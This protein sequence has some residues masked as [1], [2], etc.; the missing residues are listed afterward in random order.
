MSLKSDIKRYKKKYLPELKRQ[1]ANYQGLQLEDAIKLAVRAVI[2]SHSI[3]WKTK[4]TE[5]LLHQEND[6]IKCRT[7]EDIY[8]IAENNIKRH[9]KKLVSVR[10]YDTALRIGFN[11]NIRPKQVYISEEGIK[12]FSRIYAQTHNHISIPIEYFSEEIQEL[13]PYEI[14]DFL[15]IWKEKFY[16]N[17]HNYLKKRKLFISYSIPKKI[18]IIKTTVAEIDNQESYFITGL[19]KLGFDSVVNDCLFFTQQDGNIDTQ[20]KFHI[21]K[22]K[23]FEASAVFLRKQLNG[24]YKPQ[25]YLYDYTGNEFNESA[26]TDIQ[27]K[28]WSN[29]EIPLACIFY[30]SEIKILDCTTRIKDDNTP[31]YLLE[32]LGLSANIHKLYNSQLAFKLKSGVFWEQEELKNK[33]KFQNSAYDI[34]ISHIKKT[35]DDFVEEYKNEQPAIISKLIIQSILIKYLEERVDSTGGKLFSGKYFKKFQKA[36]SFTDVLRKQGEC[37][38]LFEDLDKD[39]NGNIFSWSPEEKTVVQK[40]NLNTLANALDAN[41]TSTHGQMS[42]WRYYE[43]NYVPVELISRLYEE[44]LGEDKQE[45]GLFYTPSHLVK[46]LVDEAM[47]LNNYQNVDVE[48]YKI[49]DPA[50]GSGVFLVTAYKRLIQWWRL[51]NSFKKPDLPTLKNIL[52]NNIHGVDKEPQAVRL[53]AFSLCLAL[54]DELTPKQI[55]EDLE[56]EDLTCENILNSDF[57]KC[58]KLSNKKF[59]LIIGNPPFQRG[60]IRDYDENWAYAGKKVKIPQGQIALKFLTDSFN[61][62]NKKGILCLI[63]KSSGLLYNTSSEGFKQLLFSELDV[64]QV[65]DFTALARNKSLWDNGADVAAAAI[66]VRNQLPSQNNNILHV[67]FRR[68]KATKERIVFEIDEYDLHYITRQNAINNNSIWKINLLGGGRIRNLIDK[69]KDTKILEKYLSDNA[70]IAGEGFI[71]GKKGHLTPDYIYKFPTLPTEAI[72]EEGIN[73]KSLVE[74]DKNLKFVKVSEEILFKAPNILVWENIGKK[75]LPMFYNETTSFSYRDK[76]VGIA[77]KNGDKE[78]LQSIADSLNKFSA[79]YRFYIYCTSSQLLINLNTA[80][81]KTDLMQ[82]PFLNSNHKS[83][84]SEYDEKIIDDINIYM[85]DFL[86]HGEKSFAVNPIKDSDINSFIGNYG[87]EFSKI[88]NLIYSKDK[89]RFRLTDVVSLCNN[90]FTASIFKYDESLS[91]VKFHQDNSSLNLKELTDNEISRHLSVNRIIKLY[92]KKDTI[93]FVKP[94]QYR[95]WLS[96]I[97]YRDADKCFS[98]L[99]KLGY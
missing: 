31:V 67:T 40:L 62:L 20:I 28:L 23:E 63:I 78:I 8:A 75:R 77:S 42:F 12:E 47:P 46:L 24:S 2:K 87:E 79:F 29:G 4:F 53:S 81:L 6:I 1:E 61:Y 90:T 34:L 26:L 73:Y 22:A 51:Q 13:D 11:R 50:C 27:R 92:P 32:S 49:L 88:L 39:F 30:K 94:N 58:D 38:K 57:F 83:E 59:D 56:F 37:V 80:I 14:H 17:Y 48:N 19:E 15:S 65:L 18:R 36:N 41:H 16:N 72:T 99:S 68:T 21:E 52:R 66:F 84:F 82:L 25:A 70:C 91:E 89:K 93:I 71:V 76:I 43:F 7:F 54:C 85:Q 86:A 60:A 3:Q 5:E 55:I 64:V 45:K 44:F 10:S 74:L 96:L 35:R 97:A 33:F 95:Y 69:F 98:D 9:S